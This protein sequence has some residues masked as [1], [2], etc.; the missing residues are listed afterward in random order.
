MVRRAVLNTNI[1]IDDFA[2][3]RRGTD[4]AEAS[5]LK[6]LMK[7]EVVL[8]FSDKLEEQILKVAKRLVSK[9]YAGFLRY[10]IWISFNVDYVQVTKQQEIIE[11][12]RDIPRKDLLIF[13]TALFGDADYLVSNNRAFLKK[14]ADINSSA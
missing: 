6:H 7:K 5:I 4:S 2:D 3:I 1:F 9:D 8:I 12:H 11:K 10:F 13:L 14:Q